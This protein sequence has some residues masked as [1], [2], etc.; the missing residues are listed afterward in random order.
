M[1]NGIGLTTVRGTAT[2]GHVQANRSHVR[3]ARMRRQ[4]ER[5]AVQQHKAYN[6][7]SAVARERGNKDIQRHE[8]KRRLENRLLEL[9]EE[10]EENPKVSEQDIERRIQDERERQVKI[11]KDQDERESKQATNGG[12]EATKVGEPDIG[13]DKDKEVERAREA[14]RRWDSPN[15]GG[16]RGGRHNQGRWDRGN[17]QGRGYNNF[18]RGR[19]RRETNTHMDAKLKEQENERL[20]DA[21]GIKR[22]THVEGQAFD[23]ELQAK[24]REE[25][26]LEHESVRKAEEKA[27]RKRARDKKRAER[28]LKKEEKRGRSKKRKRRR[29]SSSTSSSSSSSS[30]SSYSRSSSSSYSSRSG[31]MRSGSYSS[32]SSRSAASRPPSKKSRCAR[33]R[34]LSSDSR[35]RSYS[36]SRSRSNS[37]IGN[38][39]NSKDKR[40]KKDRSKSRSRSP[41]PV[42]DKRKDAAPHKEPRDEK[43]T[44]VKKRSK[45]SPSRSG[46]SSRSYSRSRSSSSSRSPSPP[47]RKKRSIPSRSRSQ[48]SSKS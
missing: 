8:E 20:A 15:Y 14:N 46:S 36:P 44:D 1:Y 9:R 28:Q 40:A 29:R 31:S 22:D 27:E 47:R 32:K 10:L 45:R 38:S 17:A 35:S 4:R 19:R 18:E 16:G 48:S 30:R 33:K 13:G 12:D 25:R 5:N 2:S 42:V 39:K 6:P 24:K 26:L 7:V 23:Q 11:W 34:S 3:G 43:E 37:T 41:S 21:F